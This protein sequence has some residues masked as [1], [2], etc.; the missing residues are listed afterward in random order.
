LILN[1]GL[2]GGSDFFSAEKLLKK[3]NICPTI[4]QGVAAIRASYSIGNQGD[5]SALISY[6]L[7]LNPT[8][9]AVVAAAA[10]PQSLHRLLLLFPP[11]AGIFFLK[12][13]VFINT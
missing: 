10:A 8:V 11:I 2:F 1:F 4:N 3:K 5:P 13:R 9:R 7:P 12:F 6:G